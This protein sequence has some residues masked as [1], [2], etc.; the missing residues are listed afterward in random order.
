M[1][2]PHS[3]SQPPSPANDGRSLTADHAEFCGCD[4]CSASKYRIRNPPSPHDMRPPEPP[5]TLRPEKPKG[6]IRRLSMPVGNAFSLDSKKSNPSL[7]TGMASPVDENG[8]IRRSSEQRGNSNLNMSN[9]G[10]R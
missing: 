5:I 7:K 4:T 10:R 3:R 6:W 1:M 9:A 2:L 8:R